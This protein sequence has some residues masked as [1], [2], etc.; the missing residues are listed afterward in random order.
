[1]SDYHEDEEFDKFG[2]MM[3]PGR[4]TVSRGQRHLHNFTRTTDPWHN[5]IDDY[6]SDDDDDDDDDMTMMKK[7]RDE[8]GQD[9]GFD[10][11]D[12]A[13]SKPAGAGFHESY[14]FSGRRPRFGKF[15]RRRRR[16][17]LG[18]AGHRRLAK[19]RAETK[20]LERRKRE[21]R[22]EAKTAERGER[23]QA[24]KARREARRARRLRAAT[25]KEQKRQERLRA[26]IAKL[27]EETGSGQGPPFPPRDDMEEDMYTGNE[28]DDPVHNL[29]FNGDVL[30][31][32]P[33]TAVITINGSLTAGKSVYDTKLGRAFFHKI[34]DHKD[35][36]FFGSR[37]E[38][39][40]FVSEQFGL[41]FS[42]ATEHPHTGA[43]TIRADNG[44]KQVD[45]AKLEPFTINTNLVTSVDSIK[46][47]DDDADTSATAFEGGWK[48]TLLTRATLHGLYGGDS[49]IEAAAG[50]SMFY[51]EDH[52]Q[53]EDS[54]VPVI[55]HLE[56]V[57]PV[58]MQPHEG[59]ITTEF[60]AQ[61]LDLLHPDAEAVDGVADRIIRLSQLGASCK[62]NISTTVN[63][64]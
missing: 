42:N 59:K 57:K 54:E 11:D 25:L 30:A 3:T 22:K 21:L 17:R 28:F 55:M 58:S 4:R 52:I 33:G 5:E 12:D 14:E 29:R 56:S 19:E 50:D 46:G 34:M 18:R 6:Y 24:R 51:F 62:V 2:R 45:V 47:F 26:E 63:F 40:D 9:D 13:N 41:D 32:V 36:E 27:E 16:G 61:Y 8:F 10:S 37:E 23:R 53:N 39:V 60:S 20:E 7:N 49:G 38:A 31:A 1:M 43:L 44:G 15:G 64:V 35:D 48:A